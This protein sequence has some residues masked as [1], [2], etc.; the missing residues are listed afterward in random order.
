MWLLKKGVPFLWDEASQA[1]FNVLKKYL[2]KVPLLSPPNYIKYFLL[3]LE[4]F[5][6]TINVVLVQEDDSLQEHVIYYLSHANDWT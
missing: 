4:A 5:D 1:S 6:S 3:Y 2:M